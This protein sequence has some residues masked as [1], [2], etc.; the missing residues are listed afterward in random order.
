M[1]EKGAGT[2]ALVWRSAARGGAAA[3]V[4]VLN[5]PSSTTRASSSTSP[6]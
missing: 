3:L 4:L 2:A 1:V 5:L 6:E